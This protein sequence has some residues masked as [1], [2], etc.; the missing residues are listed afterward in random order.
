M[1]ALTQTL[2]SLFGSGVMLPKTGITMN[3]GML[4]SIPS[5]IG[6]TRS[7]RASGRFATSAPWS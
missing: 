4:W 3:N 1:V 5:P 2:M 6:P 7:R